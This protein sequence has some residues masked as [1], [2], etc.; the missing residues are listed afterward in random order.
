MKIIKNNNSISEILGTVILLGMAVSL[1]SVVYL[2][3]VSSFVST[4]SPPVNLVGSIED[5][6]IICK[7]LKERVPI[8]IYDQSLKKYFDAGAINKFELE[9]IYIFPLFLS[10]EDLG[11]LI[12]D[13]TGCSIDKHRAE[14]IINAFGKHLSLAISRIKHLNKSLEMTDSIMSS[15]R[16]IVAETLSSMAIHSTRHRIFDI[17]NVLRK[18]LTQKE[19][20]SIKE[21]VKSSIDIDNILPRIEKIETKIDNFIREFQE[22]KEIYEKNRKI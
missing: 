11:V 2:T 17:V 8:A 6:N 13:F 19:I 10:S 15:S 7:T 5:N 18:K 12:V 9:N 4:Q 22:F 1:F 21:A 20:N 14:V 16:F 3:V